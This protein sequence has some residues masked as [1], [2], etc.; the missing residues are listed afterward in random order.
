MRASQFEAILQEGEQLKN[1]SLSTNYQDVEGDIELAVAQV[2]GKT[3]IDLIQKGMLQY[4]KG[5]KEVMGID[6]DPFP[7]LEVNMVTVGMAKRLGS[8]VEKKKKIEEEQMETDGESYS[9]YPHVPKFPN[10]YL[11]LRYGQE[12][13]Y[14]EA[15]MAEKEKKA[16]FSKSGLRFNTMGGNDLQIYVGAKLIYEGIDPG[17]FNRI[18]SDHCYRPNDGPFLFRGQPIK[19]ARPGVPPS[20][21]LEAVEYQ[22]PNWGRYPMHK[23]VAPRR[24]VGPKGRGPYGH[25]GHQPRMVMPPNQNHEEWIQSGIPSFQQKG[26]TQNHSPHRKEDCKESLQPD[27]TLIHG[28]I[29]SP[30]KGWKL[31]F[32]CLDL[33]TWSG[34][35]IKENLVARKGLIKGLGGKAVVATNYKGVRLGLA[36]LK[37]AP[38]KLDDEIGADVKAILLK[39]ILKKNGKMRIRVDFRDSNLASLKDQ[40]PMPVDDLL[41]DAVVGHQM[42]SFMDGNA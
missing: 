26:G 37:P 17:L 28:L 19:P 9:T 20:Q 2:I 7:K 35:E 30:Q 29:L 12:V 42:L 34:L 38:G 31:I 27:D 16:A 39:L 24:G 5:N 10:D 41:V 21:N 4:S 18:E 15:M 8:K 14:A 23:G 11:C 40:Y 33:Q 32:Q 22:F 13:K 6:I 1:T 36:D 3:P 25:G